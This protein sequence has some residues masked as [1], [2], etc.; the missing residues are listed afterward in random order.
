MTKIFSYHDRTY[1][2]KNL[3][4]RFA[5]RTRLKKSMSAIDVSEG[6]RLVDYGCG[7]GIFLNH[8]KKS[9]SEN[10]DLLGFEPYMESLPGNQLPMVKN[11]CEV[12]A[13]V[14]QGGSYDYVTCFEVLEHFKL[15][16]QRIAI[17][18]MK[19]IIGDNGRIVISVPI[20]KGFPAVIKNFI[21]RKSH[22]QN[23]HIYS[24][25]NI[26]KS[27]VGASLLEHRK[28]NGYLSHLGFYYSDLEKILNEK[29]IIELK[30][31]S[32]FRFAGNQLNSQVFYICKPK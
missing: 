29:C 12:L 9:C 21:R 28:S 23:K 30:I 1:N 18:Q 2:S 31:F 4:V 24:I 25:K 3:L 32:P 13:S 14:D 17:D 8:L 20:E 10:L 5:H 22:P 16:R 7:D 27:F 11:W 26:W 19:S 6:L 15:D